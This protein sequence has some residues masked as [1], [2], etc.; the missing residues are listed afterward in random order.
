MGCPG[1]ILNLKTLIVEDNAFF[2]EVL[3]EKLQALSSMMVIDE[4]AEGFEADVPPTDVRV[5]IY[6]RTQGL[7]AIVQVEGADPLGA[8]QPVEFTNRF[9]VP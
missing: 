2:R 7:Q 4:A 8:D 1:K 5:A 6:T 9:A 3:K